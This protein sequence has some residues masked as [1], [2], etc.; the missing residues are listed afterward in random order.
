MNVT[1]MKKHTQGDIGRLIELTAKHFRFDEKT[2][3]ELKGATEKQHLAF[4]I[5][6]S[7]LHFA[8]TAGK[9][10]AAS[11]DADHGGTVDTNGLKVNVV[12]A[13]MSILRLAELLNMS[14]K[15]IIKAI[16]EKYTDRISPIDQDAR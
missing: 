16:E 1:I 12:K 15:D 11:E 9:I 10:A 4:A 14:E 7:A 13:L 6:H 2:Y 8:K 5:K 3:P